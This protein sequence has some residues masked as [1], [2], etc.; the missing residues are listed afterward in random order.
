M[1]GP[2]LNPEQRAAVAHDE[3]PLLIF[4]GAGSGKTR[5]ITHRAARLVSERNVKPWRI[6]AVTFTN[7]AAGEMRHRLGGL[8]GDVARQIWV[9][10]F[11]ATCARIL[12]RHAED[13]GIRQDF[14]IYDDGEQRAVINRVMQELKLD[15]KRCPPKRL[16][17]WIDRAKQEARGPDD[18]EKNDPFS[19]AAAQ[20]Y[21]AYE[22]RM[23]ASGAVDFGDLLLMTLRLA[24]A[25]TEAGRAL[26]AKFDYV[27]VDEF[28]DTNH[29]QYRLVRALASGTRN[30]CVVGDDDQAIYRWR[31]ADVRNILGFRED[32]PDATV[33]KLEQN[34]RSTKRILRAS[35]AVISKSASREPKELW[36]DNADGAPVTLVASED[37]RDEARLIVQGIRELRREGRSL[38]DMAV[39]Y[40]IHA[41]S[42][43]IEEALRAANLPYVVVGGI[44]FY[45]RAEIKDLLSY[46]RVIANPHDDV[47]LLRIVNVPP[48]GIGKTTTDRLQAA[49]AETGESIWSVLPRVAPELGKAASTKLAAFRELV[50]A[51]AKKAPDLKPSEL[52]REVLEVTGY[53]RAL[54][55]EDSAEA[56][57]R[58]QN[59]QEILG[60]MEEFEQEAEVPT[61]AAWLE[62]VS[63]QSATDEV[64]EGDRLTMMTV[65]AAKGLEFP[66]VFVTG[67]E[68]GMFPYR[69]LDGDEEELEEERR[70][71]YVAFTRARERLV[72]SHAFVRRLF[73]T[74]KEGFPSRFVDELPEG[75]VVRVGKTGAFGRATSSRSDAWGGGRSSSVPSYGSRAASRFGA[76]SGASSSPSPARLGSGSWRPSAQPAR[77]STPAAQSR[78][79]P[80]GSYVD[81]S[82]ADDIPRDGLQ[83]GA[84]VRHA[85]F[86]VGQVRDVLPGSPVRVSV[87]FP[88]WGLKQIVASF[89]EPA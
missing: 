39:F 37:E 86:G 88:N 23:R 36:T 29:V 22:K 62:S 1:S 17:A 58:K 50:E 19:Q 8:L 52:A 67:L 82:M 69:G 35:H 24:E 38:R 78:G 53:V 80:T 14:V 57:A 73:G 30:V 71:A 54:E 55:S 49:G 56:D 10:T 79:L 6:L 61:L 21:Q 11:H 51:L 7:K 60:S 4:A 27:L 5:V 68:E 12:R 42:R 13:V 25:D 76:G 84:R 85:K 44:R 83:R 34:Y 87:Q 70:L 2:P 31:G 32:F 45:D 47:G 3:G 43:V 9:G 89:L 74:P 81:R 15:D 59:L 46:L 72:L 18:V 63:L 66:V 33:I 20:V 48:R 65:H 40:R 28:Q 16:A 41:Q 64:A 77:T 75:D 26:R